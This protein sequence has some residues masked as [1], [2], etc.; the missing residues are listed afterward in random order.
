VVIT[1]IQYLLVLT[2]VPF[3]AYTIVQ[4]LTE[5]PSV[6]VPPYVVKEKFIQNLSECHVVK[7]RTSTQGLT[8]AVTETFIPNQI[9]TVVV[10]LVPIIQDLIF[11]AMETSAMRPADARIV[12]ELRTTTQ[13]P[14]V[15]AMASCRV[16]HPVIIAVVP[17][18]IG[19]LH[20][21]AATT[22][23]DQS[24]THPTPDAVSQPSMTREAACA[25]AVISF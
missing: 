22:M 10:D 17:P 3:R 24:H 11:V 5:F 15:V 8:C 4:P 9:A 18:C 1:F 6:Q 7:I 20:R 14:N 12:V 13:V 19:I 16:H 21:F 23:S 25:T 2:A